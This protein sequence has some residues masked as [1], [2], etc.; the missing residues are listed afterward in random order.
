MVMGL[1][2]NVPFMKKD[3]SNDGVLPIGS[4]PRR[5]EIDRRYLWKLE[6]I[7]SSS[8]SWEKDFYH[9]EE[10]LP[11][12][13]EFRGALHL[14]ASTL[15]GGLRLMEDAEIIMGKLYAYA[16]MRSHEDM[17][18]KAAQALAERAEL[19]LVKLSA[20][21]SFYTPEILEMDEIKI[22]EFM[23]EE[24]ELQIYRFFFEDLMRS[25]PHTL[26]PVEEELLARSGEI[27]RAP[28]NIF[29][30]FTNADIKFPTVTDEDGNAIELSEERYIRLIRSQ[31][32]N[33]RHEAYE[34]LFRTYDQYQ[35]SLAAMYGASVKGDIFYSQSR[36]YSNSLEAALHPDNISS[37]VYDMVV[38]T[39]RDNLEPLHEYVQL[40]KE[41]LALPELAMCDLYVPLVDEPQKEI[42][43]EDACN[44]VLDGLRPL[45]EEYVSILKEGFLSGWIDVYEN[46]GKRKGAYSWGSYGT[47]PYVLL[48]YNG[49]IHD[50][51][52]IAHEMGHAIHTWYSHKHQPYVYADYTIFLAEVAS[53]TN[54]ALLLQFLLKNS[55]KDAERRYLLNYSLEQIRTTVYR[56]A[57]FADFEKMTHSMMEKGEPLTADRLSNIWHELNE[58]YYGSHISVDHLIDI[59]WAR[60]PHF[61]S[62][63]YVYKYVTG[64]AAATSLS[65]KILREGKDAQRQ[66]IEFLK[67]GRSAYSLNILNEAGVNMTTS[68]PL[69]DTI[70][71]FKKNLM[72]MKSLL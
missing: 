37:S 62:A 27:A 34:G 67:K 1:T 65:Q 39:V 16:V 47:H 71:L 11:R 15:L 22:R 55:R 42:S 8:E 5:D 54:E 51:F 17:A 43:Y 6:D 2:K 19:L 40:R 69:L 63:F 36:K 14:S 13:S 44:V 57:M 72:E 38:D 48:N 60:I 58:A 70:A 3:P 32:R 21:V 28:E 56:Q 25:R 41:V 18:N 23:E 7:Y 53:T 49:T 45:G 12:F 29:S 66:Y 10:M 50:M 59:E 68:Q 26:S 31:N 20:A 61:Y 52:T 30:L 24:K 46:E 4:L 33:V 9:L 35:N 64:Y